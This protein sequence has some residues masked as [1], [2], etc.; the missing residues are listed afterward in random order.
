MAVMTL[1]TLK[2][3]NSLKAAGVPEK[4]AEA[5]ANIFAEMMQVNL[6]ELA[7]KQDVEQLGKDLRQEMQQLGK[8]LRSDTTQLELRIESKLEKI[9]GEQVLIRW[10]LGFLLAGMVAMLIRMFVMKGPI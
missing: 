1:D 6:K 9:R 4:Q 7:T 2:M 3:A 8:E 5:E 10:M